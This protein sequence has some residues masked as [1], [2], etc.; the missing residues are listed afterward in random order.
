MKY[1]SNYT[2][3]LKIAAIRAMFPRVSCKMTSALLGPKADTAA[4]PQAAQR[5][6]VPIPF[7]PPLAHRL[8]LE[9]QKRFARRG[10]QPETHP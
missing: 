8:R 4:E 1:A 6:R 7:P 9:L 3:I 10:R 2:N 5:L